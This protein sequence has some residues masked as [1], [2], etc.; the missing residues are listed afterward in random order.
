[1]CFNLFYDFFGEKNLKQQQQQ[2][3]N[4]WNTEKQICSCSNIKVGQFKEIA[5]ASKLLYWWI[6]TKKEFSI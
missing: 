1:M 3:N 4:T 2:Y 5:N 6:Y